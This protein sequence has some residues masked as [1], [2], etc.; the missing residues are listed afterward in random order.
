MAHWLEYMAPLYVAFILPYKWLIDWSMWALNT[1]PSYYLTNGSFIGVC[2]LSIHGLHIT[3]HMAHWLEYVSPLYMAFTLPYKWLTD[4]SAW[5]LYM[6]PSY[7]LTNGS[8]IGVC[9]PSI[10]GLHITLQMAH[11]LE[12]MAPL[13]MAFI[14]PYKWLTDWS[15][16]PLYTWPS[17]Y[18]TNGSLIGVCEHSIHGLHITLQMAH[19]LECM[20][21][22][23]VAF[24]LS[25]K[26]LIDWSTWPLYTWPS[27]YL[28]NGSLIGVRDPCKPGFH[29]TLQN[30]PSLV[31]PLTNN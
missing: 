11:W 12:C 5:P 13:Y 31:H 28:T 23:Y 8:L 27:Y 19:W 17:Y 14:L 20:A 30:I 22:L 26:W 18:L 7:Y 21:P 6:W 9:E 25:Y 1:W 24:I 16:W 15:A 3:L 10:R 2:E 29:I 4:W